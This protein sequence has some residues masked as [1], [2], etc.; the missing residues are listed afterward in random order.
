MK[1]Y[2]ITVIYSILLSGCVVQEY[3]AV[4]SM[5]LPQK[6]I[7]A[8]EENNTS[9]SQHWWVEFGSATLNQLIDDAL[10][11]NYDVLSA[12]QKIEQAKLQLANADAALL[13]KADFSSTQSNT[14]E[15]KKTT[16]NKATNIAVN[17]NYEIDLLGKVK[18]TYASKAASATLEISKYDLEAAK[19]MLTS[20]IASGY[21]QY[22]ILDKRIS[23]AKENVQIAQKIYEIINAK[24]KYGIA[25]A[26]DISR[27]KSA[28]LYQQ[29]I[30]ISLQAQKQQQL[31]ALAILCGKKPQDFSLEAQS[32]E[33]IKT[34]AVSPYIPSEL[35]LH[36]PDIASAYENFKIVEALVDSANSARFPSFSL[37][38]NG[39]IASGTLLSFSNPTTLL[40]GVFGINYNLFDGGRLLQEA[41][42]QESRA[43]VAIL[44]YEKTLITAFK[45]VEDAL[46]NTALQVEQN[47]LQDAIYA[48]SEKTFLLSQ[49]RYKEGTVDLNTLL[50]TQKSFFQAKESLAIQKLSH[51][52]AIVTL[53]KTLGGGWQK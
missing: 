38:A 21:F 29:S 27:Q 8:Q 4:S 14:I 43:N 22:L 26:I 47:K 17:V 41:K 3:K 52:N 1:S 25:S 30:L 39:G 37:S 42:I 35:L 20:N 2:Y 44:T 51:L 5:P 24:Y 36:R 16:S 49:I 40:G 7:Y 53:V 23:I 31:S 50:E 28:L 48:E 15:D 9:I 46:N 10:V 11:Q 45:E 33:S 19:L 13:P 34:I 6:F 12:L 32:I 18:S